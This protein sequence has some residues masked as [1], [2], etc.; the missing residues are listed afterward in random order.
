MPVGP[1]SSTGKTGILGW[2]TALLAAGALSV[3]VL[4][5]TSYGVFTEIA[6][7]AVSSAGTARIYADSTSHTLKLSTNGGAYSDVGAVTYKNTSPS[8]AITGTTEDN[9]IFDR[10]HTI[11]ANTLRVGSVIRIRACAIHTA[12]TGTE[13]TAHTLQIGATVIASQSGNN[14]DDNHIM[15]FDYEVVVHTIGA[16]G[17]AYATGSRSVGAGGTGTARPTVVL[18]T[19]LDTT[20]SNNVGVWIDRQASATDSDSAYLATITVEVIY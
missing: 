1:N 11:P 12:T 18:G 19:T 5:F 9:T 8:T 20:A 3:G 7:P 4:T 2:V 13:T 17:T 6:A 16:G 14:F 15:Y 10:Y